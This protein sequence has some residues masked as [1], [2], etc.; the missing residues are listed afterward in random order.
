MYLALPAGSI[1]P[2]YIPLF[3]ASFTPELILSLFSFAS[4]F[5]SATFLK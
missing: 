4:F 1:V 5:V 3:P 2:V